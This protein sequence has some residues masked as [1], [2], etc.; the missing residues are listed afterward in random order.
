MNHRPE[1]PRW[2]TSTML[3]ATADDDLP[4]AAIE[5]ARRGCPVFPCAP[6]G[7]Q[8][9]TSRGFHDAS[10]DP[11]RVRWWWRR[12]PDANIGIPTGEASG[13]LVVD[14]DVHGADN[15]FAAFDCARSA[16]L[17]D[18]WGWLTRTPSGGLH[19]YFPPVR[20]VQQRSWQVPGQHIDFRADGGYV[21]A[22][23]SR[24]TVDGELRRY[25]VIAVAQHE[26]RPLDAIRLRRFLDPP[27]L[28][29]PPTS[30]SPVG[31]RP[32]KLA[33]WVASRPEGSRNH[34]LFWAACRM[35]EGGHGYDATLLVLGEAA[36]TAGLPERES[37]ATIR[38]AHRIASRLS[39]ASGP[40]PTRV[41]EGVRL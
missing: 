26:P 17:V 16:G 33:A 32:D 5:L 12:N 39:P 15:G 29:P 41:T 30:L 38:S 22:P 11:E 18:G 34:G 19:A 24:I 10:T 3:Q 14:V 4:T 31:A 7:K 2:S 40:H 8:P 9:L 20:G 1:T 37:E 25:E 6:D 36:R 23:P 28:G 21:I 27:H 35:A 13:V